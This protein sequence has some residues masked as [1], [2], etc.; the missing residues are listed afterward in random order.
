MRGPK[1]KGQGNGY[2]ICKEVKIGDKRV[3]GEGGGRWKRSLHAQIFPA[4]RRLPSLCTTFL[5]YRA[6]SFL[7]GWWDITVLMS[8]IS[9]CWWKSWELTNLSGGTHRHLCL[10]HPVLQPNGKFQYAGWGTTGLSAWVWVTATCTYLFFHL[11]SISWAL[12]LCQTQYGV[13]VLFCFV[14]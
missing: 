13:W 9:P 12:S 4:H 10:E 2:I 8:I 11:M 5:K 14:S 1:T 7:P 3:G 6:D